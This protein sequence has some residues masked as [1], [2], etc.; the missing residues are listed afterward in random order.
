MDHPCILFDKYKMVNDLLLDNLHFAHMFQDKGLH[1]YFEYKHDLKD[2]QNLIHIPAYNLHKDFQY[3]LGD[4][5]KIQH[6]FV[7]D[8]LH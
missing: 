7:L 4:K 6:R 5:C 3:N 8:K 2:N 1:T